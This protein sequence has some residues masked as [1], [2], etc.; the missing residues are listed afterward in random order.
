MTAIAF[1]NGSP[2][3]ASSVS[4]EED[5][6]SVQTNRAGAIAK[7]RTYYNISLDVVEVPT[8]VVEN[9]K[10]LSRV[11]VHDGDRLVELRATPMEVANGE[12]CLES[13]KSNVRV[14]E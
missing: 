4:V 3:L 2:V 1:F 14:I 10:K 7:D 9:D 11:L 8:K 5:D 13:A 12:L 6:V